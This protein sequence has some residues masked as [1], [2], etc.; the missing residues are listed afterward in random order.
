MFIWLN[1][2]HAYDPTVFQLSRRLIERYIFPF[3]PLGHFDT[4]VIDT[5]TLVLVLV[6]FRKDFARTSSYY[7]ELGIVQ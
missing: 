3:W 2:G 7:A 4:V 5:G 1:L 6:V